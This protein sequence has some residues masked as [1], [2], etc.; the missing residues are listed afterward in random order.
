MG[1]TLLASSFIEYNIIPKRNR[2]FIGLR[3]RSKIVLW[4]LMI[5]SIEVLERHKYI[6]IKSMGAKFNRPMN[7]LLRTVRS[8]PDKSKNV[9]TKKYCGV[10]IMQMM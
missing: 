5:S 8:N 1:S 7:F 3:N 10:R 9:Q 6:K 4:C 2:I